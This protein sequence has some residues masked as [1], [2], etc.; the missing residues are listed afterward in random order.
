MG[1]SFSE[2]AQSYTLLTVG[3]GLVSQ[4]PAL[5]VSTA[6]GLLVSKAGVSGRADK[7]LLGQLGAFPRALGVTSGLMVTLAL[8]PGLPAIPFLALAAGTGYLAY[9]TRK[10]VEDEAAE[11]A[12]IAEAE[13]VPPPPPEEPISTALQIDPIRLELGYG[14]LSLISQGASGRLTDQIKALRRQMASELGF[15]M[16]SV[17]IQDNIQLPANTYIVKI[18]ELETGR[19]DVR[20]NML[21]VMDPNGGDIGL[22]GE[23]TTEPAFGLAAMWIKP[24]L[25]EEASFR[26]LTVVDPATVVTTHITEILKDNLSEMLNF[27]QTQKLLQELDEDYQKL[28]GELVPQ[29]IS[30]AGIQRILQSLLAERISVRDLPLI[31]EAIGEALTHTQS[32]MVITEHVRSRLAR[33]ISN[34]NTGPGGYIPI[35]TLSGTWEE[36]FNAS[37]VGQGEQRQLTMGPTQ[38]QEFIQNMRDAFEQQA[39]RGE[40][41]VLVTS[42]SIRPY[43]R[44]IVER[45]RPSSVVLSQNE[46]FPRARIRTLGQV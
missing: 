25:R 32:I 37:L 10:K 17:R 45:F 13:A 2:A 40:L 28:L 4:I 36:A 26:G 43:V 46:I 11:A 31:L 30:A 23:D 39:M 42:P 38:L 41:P 29:K 6:A 8:L 1:I 12:A 18:K 9:K 34:A 16:P 44:S 5:I 7:A 20:P 33:Q 3:D 21:M 22:P 24:E 15:V 19:G 27:A 14:L 35:L